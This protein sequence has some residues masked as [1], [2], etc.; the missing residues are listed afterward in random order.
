MYTLSISL[1][2]LN[3]AFVQYIVANMAAKMAAVMTKRFQTVL[4]RS[5]AILAPRAEKSGDIEFHSAQAQ[6]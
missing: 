2:S 3:M 6:Q 5:L 4:H 1:T